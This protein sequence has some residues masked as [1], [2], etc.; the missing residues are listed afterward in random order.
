MAL[1]L[2][3]L[4]VSIDGTDLMWL[5]DFCSGYSH[6]S[7]E[8]RHLLWLTSTALQMSSALLGFEDLAQQWS[9]EPDGSGGMIEAWKL[10]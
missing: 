3:G 9:C 4:H 5:L 7:Y 6:V 1:H 10:S 8:G 2:T